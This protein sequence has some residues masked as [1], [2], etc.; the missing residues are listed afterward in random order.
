MTRSSPSSVKIETTS[1]ERSSSVCPHSCRRS[2]R[3]PHA[4]ATYAEVEE[5]EADLERFEKWLAAI[6]ARDY[7]GAPAGAA[8]RRRCNSVATTWQP[9]KPPLW[10]QSSVRARRTA[11]Q[12]DQPV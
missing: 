1:I 6:T 3:K 7:F 5:S 10:L 11:V 2:L 8:A 12:R 9:S 4:A